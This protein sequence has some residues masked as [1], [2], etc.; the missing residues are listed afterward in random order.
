MKLGRLAKL[1]LG[2]LAGLVLAECGVRVWNPSPAVQVVRDGQGVELMDLDGT[3]AW[4]VHNFAAPAFTFDAKEAALRRW[5][6]ELDAEIVLW[7]AWATDIDHTTRIGDT[8]Y[9]LDGLKVD[10]DGIPDAFGLPHNALLFRHLRLYEFASLELVRRQPRS[11]DPWSALVAEDMAVI[12]PRLEE[13]VDQ[14]L[15]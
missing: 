14:R 3:T 13:W 10:A 7:E 9:R 6:P 8:V 4:C 2:L 11:D 12:G 15:Q 1:S 5:L